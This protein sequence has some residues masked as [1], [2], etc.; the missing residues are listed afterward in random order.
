MRWMFCLSDPPNQPVQ[1]PRWQQAR[2][3]FPR[4]GGYLV[5]QGVRGQGAQGDVAVDDIR[6]TNQPCGVSV[7][8]AD[9][10]TQL[11]FPPICSRD[12]FENYQCHWNFHNPLQKQH[13]L[14]TCCFLQ[15]RKV[16]KPLRCSHQSFSKFLPNQILEWFGLRTRVCCFAKA[17]PSLETAFPE[18]TMTAHFPCCVCRR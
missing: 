2:I 10:H 16:G 5:I 7:E 3:N 17:S 11:F 13:Q 8:D 12:P 9:P 18:M 6:L 15:K 1:N 14:K 4:Q